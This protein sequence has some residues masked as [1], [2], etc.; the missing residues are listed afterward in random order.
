MAEFWLA[1]D[2]EAYGT[3]GPAALARRWALTGASGDHHQPG[4]G[5]KPDGVRSLAHSG[6]S[7]ARE[8]PQPEEHP[9]WLNSD[10]RNP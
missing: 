8:G 4:R 9:R 7:T 10:G 3:T 1:E 5:L 6:S 2:L